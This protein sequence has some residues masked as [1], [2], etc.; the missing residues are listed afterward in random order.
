MDND[1]LTGAFKSSPAPK[2][3]SVAQ[4]ALAA[5]MALGYSSSEASTA[6]ANVDGYTSVEE[7]ITEALKAKGAK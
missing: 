7:L 6:I 1:E 5:L 4:E 2:S 3:N